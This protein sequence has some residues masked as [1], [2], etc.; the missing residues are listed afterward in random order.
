MVSGKTANRHASQD[1]LI[2][3]A[4]RFS[5]VQEYERRITFD[6]ELYTNEASTTFLYTGSRISILAAVFAK[7]R[8]FCSHPFSTK[9]ELGEL[10]RAD[11]LFNLPKNNNMPESYKEA[12][13]LIEN[14]FVPLE[15][16]DVCVNDCMIFRKDS[17]DLEACTFCKEERF[18]C[19]K[20]RRTFTYFPLGQRLARILSTESLASIFVSKENDDQENICDI[21]N[22]K[23]WNI[24]WFNEDG[25]FQGRTGRYYKYSSNQFSEKLKITG[26]PRQ[27]YVRISIIQFDK[28]IAC[29]MQIKS[30]IS[31]RYRYILLYRRDEP[32]EVSKQAVF[33]VAHDG[34]NPQLSTSIP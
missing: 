6:E 13:K 31:Y 25:L 24:E 15:R 27:K 4:E 33:N 26:L 5:D 20:P 3:K 11:H 7:F 34:T 29:T 28:N 9:E 30:N 32:F 21:Q 19:G 12:R 18:E 14:F 22:T 17:V 16:Y 8:T 10:F 23:T 1:Y 2:L